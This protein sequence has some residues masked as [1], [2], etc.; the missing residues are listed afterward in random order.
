MLVASP[1]NALNIL[2]VSPSDTNQK[3]ASDNIVK[4]PSRFEMDANELKLW[5][6]LQEAHRR[7][8]QPGSRLKALNDVRFLLLLLIT[9]EILDAFCKQKFGTKFTVHWTTQS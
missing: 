2:T 8:F 3:K 1:C 4:E 5:Q 9:F 6:T 7:Q